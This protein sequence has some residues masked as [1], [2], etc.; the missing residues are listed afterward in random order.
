MVTEKKIDNWIKR[1]KIPIYIEYKDY[2]DKWGRFRK[3]EDFRFYKCDRCGSAIRIKSDYKKQDGGE[4]DLQ[5]SLLRKG[6][7]R[8][9][10]HSICLKELVKEID[11]FFEKKE[12]NSEM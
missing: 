2:K 1:K 5:A 6:D 12:K 10:T 4:Y 3:E 11:D 7:A 8:V 9:V